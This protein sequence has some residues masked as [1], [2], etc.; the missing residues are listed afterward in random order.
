M[1]PVSYLHLR[2]PRTGRNIFVTRGIPGPLTPGGRETDGGATPGVMSRQGPRGVDVTGPVR[3]DG[4]RKEK[5]VG[6]G[7]ETCW[8][9]R[10]CRR[11]S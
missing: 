9:N 5:G 8:G 4:C 6:V 11:V 10:E 7:T 1:V 2:S 3:E